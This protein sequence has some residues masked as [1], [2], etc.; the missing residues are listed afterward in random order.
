MIEA[1]QELPLDKQRQLVTDG[2]DEGLSL[3]ALSD[4]LSVTYG[5]VTI[6]NLRAFCLRQNVRYPE[7]G[8]AALQIRKMKREIRARR[9]SARE[10]GQC[11]LEAG[12]DAG[13]D[14]V[15][16]PFSASGAASAAPRTAE[17][18]AIS[19]LQVLYPD[20]K[21]ETA[22]SCG[23]GGDDA[24]EGGAGVT[25]LNLRAGQCKFPLGG[26]KEPAR[27]FCGKPQAE[28]CGS[29][30]AECYAV[31]YEPL[32]SM[33]HYRAKRRAGGFALKGLRPQMAV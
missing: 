21:D 3:Q 32:S 16:V 33:S 27:F 15:V 29:Y 23:A 7:E 1:W 5:P 28:G 14:G 12:G 8:L 9:V 10:A 2:R 6:G 13:D 19:Q 4:R 18:E 17:R 22:G 30:C 31:A 11:D 20:L 26:P 24:A 25:L